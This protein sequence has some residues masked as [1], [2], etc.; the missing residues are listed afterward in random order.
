SVKTFA[1]V[2]KP[3]ERPGVGPA[4]LVGSPV[5]SLR[6]GRTSRRHLQP[7]RDHR[8]APSWPFSSCSSWWRP[9]SL[10]PS[11]WPSLHLIVKNRFALTRDF[12]KTTVES[13]VER[14]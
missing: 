8:D 9:S 3:K 5:V 4:A 6:V 12:L 11:S 7:L 2:R 10:R 13:Q 1:I 14:H